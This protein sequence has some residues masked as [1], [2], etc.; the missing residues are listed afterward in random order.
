MPKTTIQNRHGL[1][2]VIDV[3][4]ATDSVGLAFISH[5]L[6][7]TMLHEHIKV[8]ADAFRKA[9]YTVVMYDATNSVGES[10]GDYSDATM[11]NYYED[12]ESVVEWASRQ[13]WYLEPFVICGHSLGGYCA[14]R[15][16]EEHPK[17]VKAL[18]PLSAAASGSLT[19]E[20]NKK[21]YP[22]EYEEWKRS[23]VR[24]TE[25]KSSPGVIKRLKWSH[26]EERMDH[27]ILP[28]AGKITQPILLMVGEHD[29]STPQEHQEMIRDAVASKDIEFHV[30]EGEEH[31]FRNSK[32][33]KEISSI[34]QSWA[35]RVAT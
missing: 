12:F 7:G 19:H 8:Y 1:D 25:S 2:L 16:T 5:G 21:F 35:E 28:D 11:K 24:V 9:G 23:G 13:P 14:L 34:L 6:G 18:A 33:L 22:E 29:D 30:I 17:K 3:T 32:A 10:G 26:M 31:T 4:E 20:A 15:F 27:D